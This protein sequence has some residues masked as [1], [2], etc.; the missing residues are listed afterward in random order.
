MKSGRCRQ[1]IERY[2]TCETAA[3]VSEMQERIISD[4]EADYAESRRKGQAIQ[5][6][7][8]GPASCPSAAREGDD[9]D[10]LVANP[11]HAGRPAAEYEIDS[12]DSESNENTSEEM[13]GS[14]ALQSTLPLRDLVLDV[15]N[16][17]FLR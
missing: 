8:R 16:A 2:R 12:D 3:Q 17:N 15:N 5:E 10:L 6:L 4:A 7:C 11:N 13:D 1:L 14:T 9:G